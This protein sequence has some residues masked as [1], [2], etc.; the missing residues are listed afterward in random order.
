MKIDE[1]LQELNGFLGPE[2]AKHGVQLELALAKLLP[3]VAID[4][5]QLRQ[6][7]L[8]LIRNA[9]EAMPEGGLI[10]LSLQ[11]TGTGIEICLDDSGAGIPPEQRENI[12]D[13]FFT[14]KEH[15]TG[16]GLPLTQQIILAHGG[17]IECRASAGGGTCFRIYLPSVRTSKTSETE[18]LEHPRVSSLPAPATIALQKDT[19]LEEEDHA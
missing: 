9:R 4:E 11:D 17:D 1:F 8:N 19:P 3:E 13:L 14:T 5:T 10:R 15:G 7:L 2:L 18:S 6:A 16:L 12:F